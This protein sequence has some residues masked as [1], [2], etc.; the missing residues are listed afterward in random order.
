M[1]CQHRRVFGQRCFLGPWAPVGIARWLQEATKSRLVQQDCEPEQQNASGS[2]EG[3]GSGS[4]RQSQKQSIQVLCDSCVS[5]ASF[6]ATL[7]LG[8]CV[9]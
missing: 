9:C 4:N 2:G 3:L 8:L 5:L 6:L 1:G 7:S